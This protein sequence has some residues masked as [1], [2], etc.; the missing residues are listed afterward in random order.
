[1]EDK[2]PKQ[3]KQVLAVLNP[4]SGKTD[5]PF[6]SDKYKKWMELKKLKK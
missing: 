3:E 4:D 2:V 5:I 1:M 6:I